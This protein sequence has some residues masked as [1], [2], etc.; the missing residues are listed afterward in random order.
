MLKGFCGRIWSSRP[1][2]CKM[3]H[4]AALLELYR[5]TCLDLAHL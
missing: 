3:H 5:S 2:V 4:W 1:D